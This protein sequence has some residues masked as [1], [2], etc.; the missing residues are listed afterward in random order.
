MPEDSQ[1]MANSLVSKIS[2]ANHSIFRLDLGHTPLNIT[3]H[4]LWSARRRVL[5]EEN[6]PLPSCCYVIPASIRRWSE[7][8]QH[9]QA[10]Y[11]FRQGQPGWQKFGP[12]KRRVLVIG[13]PRRA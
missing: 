2:N 6:R 12:R 10:F 1:P 5:D 3:L 13:E 4:K 8:I 9:R 11:R 7:P